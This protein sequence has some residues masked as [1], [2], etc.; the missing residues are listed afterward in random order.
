M[1][2]V[3]RLFVKDNEKSENQA[4]QNGATLLKTDDWTIDDEDEEY[5]M[6]DKPY[7]SSQNPCTK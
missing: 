2:L 5:P 1:V 7:V 3:Q 4:D 6:V